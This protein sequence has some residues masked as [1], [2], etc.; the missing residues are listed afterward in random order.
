MAE[1]EL[2]LVNRDPNNLN[3]HVKVRTLPSVQN[4]SACFTSKNNNNKT[5]QKTKQNKKETKTQQQQQQQQTTE[6]QN[7]NFQQ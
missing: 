4:P 1:K 5:K 3:D 2:D 7:K 6:K